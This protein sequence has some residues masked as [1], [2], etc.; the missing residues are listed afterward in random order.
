M[1]WRVGAIQSQPR[2]QQAA[3]SWSVGVNSTYA[4]Q[5]PKGWGIAPRSVWIHPGVYGLGLIGWK[6]PIRG[7]VNVAGYFSDL[8]PQWG[9]GVIWSVDKGGQTLASGTIANGG[10]SQSFSIVGVPIVAG[11][12]PYYTIDP[13]SGDYSCDRTGVDVTITKPKNL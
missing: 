9:N 2:W 10:P 13:N 4:T 6:S 12:V 5:F 7:L 11:Q 1:D 8:D 3:N